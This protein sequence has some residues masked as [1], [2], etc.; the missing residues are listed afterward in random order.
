MKGKEFSF[1]ERLFRQ[2]NWCGK[3]LCYCS[4]PLDEVPLC[5]VGVRDAYDKHSKD[6]WAMLKLLVVLLFTWL[7]YTHGDADRCS[8]VSKY[9]SHS[10]QRWWLMISCVWSV[11]PLAVVEFLCGGRANQAKRV[12]ICSINP[13][14]E[15]MLGSTPSLLF[16]TYSTGDFPTET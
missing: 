7:L 3:S 12:F 10:A 15:S 2:I 8:C 13:D 1:N 14:S 6:K 4:E 16:T 11:G 9:V 5:C